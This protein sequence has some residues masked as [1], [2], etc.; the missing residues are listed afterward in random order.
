MFTYRST[1]KFLDTFISVKKLIIGIG[2]SKK[3]AKFKV[4]EHYMY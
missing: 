2:C 4:G 1:T 3:C